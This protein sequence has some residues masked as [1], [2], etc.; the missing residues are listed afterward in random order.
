MIGQALQDGCREVEELKEQL[1]VANVKATNVAAH[2]KLTGELNSTALFAELL[3][4]LEW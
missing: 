1:S 4:D 3:L 2:A